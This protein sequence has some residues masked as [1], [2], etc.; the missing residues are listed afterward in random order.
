MALSL[1][2]GQASW[3][4]A[5]KTT[6]SAPPSGG[7]STNTPTP[8]P[9]N[10]VAVWVDDNL[11][12]GA[13]SGADGGDSW[14][15]VQ[16][17]PAPLAGTR[18]HQS[19]VSSGLHQHYFYDASQKL[20]VE[21]GESLFAYAY[22]DPSNPPSQIMLQWND[23]SWDHRAYWGANRIQYGADGSATRRYMGPLPAT[24]KWVLLQV[25]ASQ[26]SLEGKTLNGMAFSQYDGRVTWDSAGKTTG[27]LTNTPP[28]ITNTP[29]PVVTN[30]PPVVTNT[31]PTVTNTVPSTNVLD[32]SAIDYITPELPKVGDHTLHV[33]SPNLLELKLINTKQPDPARVTAWDLVDANGQFQAP[34]SS[35][36]AVT[37]DGKSVGV[38]SVGFKRR[39]L[40]ASLAGYDLRIEN[41]M[42]LQLSSP[43]SDNQ[44][45]EVKNPSGTLWNSTMKFTAE[46]RSTSLQSGHSR[47]PGGLHAQ[48]REKGHGRLLLG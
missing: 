36:F 27:Q 10:S 44:V 42:Y 29:P 22:L 16:A 1:Y 9:T 37:A 31:T 40:Y 47:E 14:S 25:P 21:S 32:V 18:S 13:K 26:V 43:V 17:S 7:G 46:N 28:V 4:C 39:P 8:A 3:D 41:S 19:S 33:L 6:V 12:S 23:G 5:G 35:A 34:A 48:P 11:P 38:A 24:G 45:I 30:N 20:T 15:W 2:G